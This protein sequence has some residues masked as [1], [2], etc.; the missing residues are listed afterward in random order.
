[1]SGRAAILGLADDEPE[2][3]GL[4]GEPR[5]PAPSSEG[6]PIAKRGILPAWVIPE[7]SPNVREDEW[8]AL[9]ERAPLDLRANAA[10]TSRERLLDQ[11]V[12]AT[13]TPHSP[14]GIRLPSDTRVDD[15]PAYREGLIEVQDEGS[16]LIALACAP[17]DNERVLDLCAGAGGKSLALAA[18][19]PGAQVLATDSNRARLSKLPARAR[20]GR[21]ADRSAAAEPAQRACRADR[22]ERPGR[23][24]PGRRALFGQRDLAAQSGGPLASDTRAARTGRRRPAASARSRRRD[25]Q[26]R[27]APGLCGMLDPVPRRGRAD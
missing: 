14:W 5:G 23:P 4:F 7:L 16:Q 3:L 1:M 18:A 9:L 21:S 26:A 22:L 11:F 8:P 15:H 27:R 13:P 20:T 19:A 6:E 24:R 12:D 17:Q 10:R 25:G 2:L